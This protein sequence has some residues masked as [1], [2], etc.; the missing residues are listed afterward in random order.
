MEELLEEAFV[1]ENEQPYE[2]PE[3]WVWTNL[4]TIANWGSGGTPSRKHSEYYNGEIPWLKTGDLNNSI[5]TQ[6]DET[7]TELG[8]Q[9]SSAKLF[10]ENSVVIAMYGA[11]IGKL[12]I[13]GMDCSTN[14]A[15]AVGIVDTRISTTKFLFYYLTSMKDNLIA[16]GKGGAQPNISQQIIKEFPFPLPPLNEQQR[17][18]EKVEHLLEKIDEA[19]RLIAEQLNHY[20]INRNTILEDIFATYIKDSIQEDSLKNHVQ[21]IQYGYTET[22]S[23]EK[24]GPKYL[25]I[26]DIQDDKVE[27]DNV[28]HCKIDENEYKKYKLELNDIVIARTGATTGKSFLIEE[29]KEDAVFASYLIRVTCKEELNPNYLW[30]FMKTPT[31]WKQIMVVKKGSAQ[32]GANA[33]I[34]GELKIP[35]PSLE[36][37]VKIANAIEITLSKIDAQKKA[38]ENTLLNIEQLK[39]S[40]LSKAFKGELGT[41]DSSDENSIELLK[42]ILQEQLN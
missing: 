38:L 31:Y 9:K 30:A 4:R 26:T 35:I 39:Q 32:P 41:N 10:P 5:I 6:T 1:I 29:L 33:K 34:L 42:S 8:L 2:I 23:L 16:K 17:I 37:Q 13:L 11:T 15:A 36:V 25:R 21:N 20:E 27:W 19:K 22:S 14:Q 40:I 3:N 7:I 28:P 24:I 12:G 18:V